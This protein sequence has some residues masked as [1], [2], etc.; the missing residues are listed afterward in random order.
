MLPETPGANEGND[1]QAKF[2]MWQREAAFFLRVR[3]YMIASTGGGVALTERSTGDR[4]T[5]G[6]SFEAASR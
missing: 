3:A 1:I 2:T 5:G 4:R 6:R